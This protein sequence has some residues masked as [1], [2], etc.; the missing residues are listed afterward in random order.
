M[1]KYSKKIKPKISKDIL[2]LRRFYKRNGIPSALEETLTEL[3]LT[4]SVKQP[5]NILEIGTATG[6]SAL[7]MLETCPSAHVT[8][9]EKDETS[10]EE[11]KKNFTKFHVSDRVKQYLGD[12]A[13]Y[14]N[15]LG[16]WFDFVFLDGAKSHYIDYLFDIKRLM[17]VHGVLFADNV[18]FRGYVDGGVAYGRGDNTI[19][20]NMR[21]FLD[22]IIADGDFICTVHEIGDGILIAQ[23]IK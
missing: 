13:E 11:A 4:V 21:K 8:T 23:K 18:L 2:E 22:T 19:V 5:K 12:A 9:I 20:N 10:F 1:D 16:G 3:V 7:I 15:Y 6:V 17:P 14:L